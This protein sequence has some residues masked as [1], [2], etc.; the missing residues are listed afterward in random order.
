MRC[1][2]WTPAP[3]PGPLRGKLADATGY[4]LPRS[5]GTVRSGA[6]VILVSYRILRVSSWTSG[7]PLAELQQAAASGSLGE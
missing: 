5:L 2:I 1:S 6:A 4:P 3:A 7:V